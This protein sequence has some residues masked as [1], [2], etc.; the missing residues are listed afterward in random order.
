MPWDQIEEEPTVTT[1]P[2]TPSLSF[3]EPGEVQPG[4]TPPVTL[5]GEEAITPVAPDI[6]DRYGSRSIETIIPS[7]SEPLN[8]EKEQITSFVADSPLESEI[9]TTETFSIQSPSD[10]A[11][12]IPSVP[13]L[14]EAFSSE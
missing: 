10:E 2:A 13:E 9:S 8:V 14:S 11:A 7:P 5:L 6:T 1:P 4:I 3:P 12:Q